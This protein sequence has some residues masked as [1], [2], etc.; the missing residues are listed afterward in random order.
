[1]TISSAEFCFII[2]IILLIFTINIAHVLYVIICKSD[3]TN[4]YFRL[5]LLNFSFS[6]L[7]IVIWLI[8]FFYFRT[9]WPSES[10]IWR[11]WSFLFHIVDAVQIYS[12]VLFIT[13]ANIINTS[14]QRLCIALTWFAPLITY[15][16]ILW[17]SSSSNGKTD[18]LPYHTLSTDV[19]WW[20]LPTLYSGT[21]L[22]PIFVSF[23]LTGTTVCW[24][25]I[26]RQY[27]RREEAAQRQA[28]EHRENMAELTSLVETVLNFELDQ[29]TM[30]T[31]NT[32]VP[33]VSSLN[34][35]TTNSDHKSLS[36]ISNT[37][38]RS[39]SY[40]ASL[41]NSFLLFDYL[42]SSTQLNDYIQKQETHVN[43]RLLFII[44]SLLLLVH[45]PYVLFSLM[46]THASQLSIFIYLHWFGTMFLPI[47]HFQKA[48]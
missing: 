29:S 12:L 6:S 35:S 47:V 30:S 8:P 18:Y 3:K 32:W 11:L 15:S 7:I 20:I 4:K 10:F 45:L 17:L 33:S 38:N 5:I 24:P 27:K 25:W 36:Y 42:S 37:L 13:H 48:N 2:T 21:Y 22:V 46:D 34:N 14:L 1:M 41:D 26:Y 43:Y 16:P 23:L 40:K 9:I 44:T 19:P 31:L 39:L 28:N